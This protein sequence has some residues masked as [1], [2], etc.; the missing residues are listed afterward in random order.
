MYVII[1]IVLN[2]IGAGEVRKKRE[3]DCTLT[4]VCFRYL[5]YIAD[6]PYWYYKC[7]YFLDCPDSSDAED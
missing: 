7:Y 3:E 4:R 1:L 5:I 2:A 6:E